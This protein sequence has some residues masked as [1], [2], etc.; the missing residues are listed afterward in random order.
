MA[1]WDSL[2]GNISPDIS[3]DMGSYT[4]PV[5]VSGQGKVFS[6]PSYLAYDKI[7]RRVV[8]IGAAAKAL[9]GR[10]LPHVEVLRPIRE[11]VIADFDGT[12]L[13]LK[14][15]LKLAN[16][17]GI[18]APRMVV[19]VPGDASDVECRAAAEVA[20]S[21][22]ARTVYI[23]PQ[24]LASAV[25]AGLPIMEAQGHLVVNIGGETIQAG[26][27]SMGEII[28]SECLRW[29]SGRFDEKLVTY[30]RNS[31]NHLISLA[32]AEELK[33]SVGS[34]LRGQ[35][36][37][38]G[39]V[40]GFDL[41]AGLPKRL[42]VDSEQIAA[43]LEEYLEEI[44]QLSKRVLEATPPELAE[45]IMAAGCVLCGGGALLR[46]IDMYMNRALRIDCYVAPD[47]LLSVVLGADMIL[48]DP[49]LL[50][51]VMNRSLVSL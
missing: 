21:A 32:N 46:G 40:C 5:L 17:K 4:T 2:L 27:I 45:D 7:Q 10:T 44:A 25:G 47:P 41:S 19:G 26:V 38:S 39:G 9:I 48:K 15:L 20:R 36:P 8:A 51:S 1:F 34:A 22:G 42:S 37:I 23:V 29:G 33:I 14:Y 3:V 50:R 6:E 13:L 35:L 43:Q 28:V 12:A 18:M 24:L 31:H 16:P 30:L 11:G 49:R